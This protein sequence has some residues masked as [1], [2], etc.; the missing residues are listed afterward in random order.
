MHV[1]SWDERE[2]DRE[3]VSVYT[4]SYACHD[5][6]VV[7]AIIIIWWIQG[8]ENMCGNLSTPAEKCCACA[9]DWMCEYM[10]CVM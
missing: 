4:K 2:R 6:V 1:H 5:V 8:N 9:C 10:M 7:V 3:W